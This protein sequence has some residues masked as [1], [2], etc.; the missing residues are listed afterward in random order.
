MNS[1]NR[2]RQIIILCAIIISLLSTTVFAQNNELKLTNLFVKHRVVGAFTYRKIGGKTECYNADTCALRF[3][4][5][6]TFKIANSVIGLETSAIPDTSFIFRYDSVPRRLAIWNRDMNLVQA[7]RTSCVPCYREL[8]RRIGQT[9]MQEWLK[10]FLY[11]NMDISGGLDTFWLHNTMQISPLE[12]L[13]FL[14]KL[15]TNKFNL[16]TNTIEKLKLMML[17]ETKEKGTWFGKTGMDM[18]NET[19]AGWLVGYVQKDREIY[20]YALIIF[21]KKADA[22][23]LFPLRIILTKKILKRLKL[24]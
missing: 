8:A 4:P 21:G 22:E 3:S 20:V 16:K 1:A 10:T 19:M 11:G 2:M 12:Q 24:F 9:R 13:D 5:A 6:S 17:L 18:S 7:F 14:E 23:S 15:W